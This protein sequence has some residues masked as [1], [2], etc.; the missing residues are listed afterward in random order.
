VRTVRRSQ[1]RFDAG[2]LAALARGSG[3]PKGGRRLR[4][5]RSRLVSRLKAEGLSNR[6]IAHR[7][8]VSEK[9]VRKLLRRLGWV[10]SKPQQ[11]RLPIEPPAADPN[12]S[13]F[14]NPRS[15]TY[16]QLPATPTRPGRED[17]H[18]AAE[19]QGRG[20]PFEVVEVALLLATV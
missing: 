11:P 16:V 3:Y 9:A 13:A 12:L 4:P 8:G 18:L 6:V 17:R 15:E 20:V 10:S 5:S 14:S 1:R 2:G 19:L 7:L